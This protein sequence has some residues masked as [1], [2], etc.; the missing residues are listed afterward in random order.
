MPG[1]KIPKIVMP[2]FDPA[3]ELS[4]RI[5]AIDPID[6]DARAAAVLYEAGQIRL[7]EKECSCCRKAREMYQPKA[8]VED[9]TE[10][11]D[12]DSVGS[13]VTDQPNPSS[14]GVPWPFLYCVSAGE[15]MDGVCA[16]CILEGGSRWDKIARCSLAV[17][18]YHLGKVTLGTAV[19]FAEED[20]AVLG[21]DAT[22]APIIRA[23]FPSGTP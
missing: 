1:K 19:C 5:D 15:I 3:D 20:V 9:Q 21:E 13:R 16:R 14:P 10:A 18:G 2:Y 4:K 23:L 12:T 7:G 17:G 11:E 22:A 8:K 6:Y